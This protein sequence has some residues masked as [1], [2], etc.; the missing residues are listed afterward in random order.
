MTWP[1]TGGYFLCQY[2]IDSA[3]CQHKNLLTW[4]RHLCQIMFLHKHIYYMYTRLCEFLQ[5][6]Y[7]VPAKTRLNAYTYFYTHL[8]ENLNLT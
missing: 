8:G 1:R 7:W 2:K 3:I 5:A 4:P 6:P